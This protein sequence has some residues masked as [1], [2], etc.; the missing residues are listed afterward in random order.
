MHRNN[1][2]FEWNSSLEQLSWSWVH[3]KNKT[4]KLRGRTFDFLGGY[5]WFQKKN[6]LQTDF[7]EKKFLQGGTWPKKK[8]LHCKNISFMEYN[9]WKNLTPLYVRKKILSQA[10]SKKKILT[11]IKSPIPLL[12]KSNGRPLNR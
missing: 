7:E 9:A 11:Q 2:K 8:I 5:G 4:Y 6:I 1:A 3:W 10:V 12:K